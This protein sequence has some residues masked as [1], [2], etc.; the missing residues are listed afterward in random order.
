MASPGRNRTDPISIGLILASAKRRARS[1]SCSASKS[2]LPVF[3]VGSG[4]RSFIAGPFIGTPSE[5]QGPSRYT[6]TP[7]TGGHQ[8]VLQA[9][10][11]P[12]PPRRDATGCRE[13][14]VFGRRDVSRFR[15]GA[16]SNAAA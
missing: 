8:F 11:F 2:T 12:E 4:E 15:E 13:A 5:V 7:D 14:K 10:A 1:A 9:Y 3:F 6:Q 16:T